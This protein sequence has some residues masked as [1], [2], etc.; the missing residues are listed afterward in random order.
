[1]RINKLQLLGL[2]TVVG[3]AF[4]SLALVIVP[5]LSA[6][7]SDRQ[8]DPD[9]KT[10]PVASHPLHYVTPVLGATGTVTKTSTLPDIPLGE[11]QN[12]LLPGSIADDRGVQLGSIGSALFPLGGNEYWTV[13]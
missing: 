3:V 11:F 8:A 10:S 4:I 2:V 13:T 6:P 12:K 9:P 7:G 1:M 5:A